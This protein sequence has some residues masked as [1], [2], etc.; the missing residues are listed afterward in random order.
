MIKFSNLNLKVA[1]IVLILNLLTIWNCEGQHEAN[2]DGLGDI[3]IHGAHSGLCF[4]YIW[5]EIMKQN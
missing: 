2:K 4:H 3:Y 5:T 1:F